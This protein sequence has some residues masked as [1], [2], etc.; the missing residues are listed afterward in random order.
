MTEE[1]KT[2]IFTKIKRAILSENCTC[3]S[4]CQTSAESKDQCNGNCRPKK[5]E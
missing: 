3:C 1:K 2:S 4:C 5:P